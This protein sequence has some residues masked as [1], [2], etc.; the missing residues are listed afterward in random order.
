MRVSELTFGN[1]CDSAF[2]G[3]C[4]VIWNGKVV[5]EDIDDGVHING[6]IDPV[7]DN[8]ISTAIQDFIAKYK[9]KKIYNF[10]CYVVYFH[11][12]ELYIEGER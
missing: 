10:Y 12:T 2:G 9:D 8:N 4:R 1:L 7:S 11:H 3:F 5:Y 6:S